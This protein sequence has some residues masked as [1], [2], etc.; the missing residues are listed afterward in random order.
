MP[1]NILQADRGLRHQRML[2]GQP[3]LAP[4]AYQYMMLEARQVRAIGNDR[5]P[6]IEP[7]LGNGRL[8]ALTT[9]IDQV[10]F[11][12]GIAALETGQQCRQE[13]TEYR[14]RRPDAHL[15]LHA[16]AEEQRFTQ[17]ILQG[18]EDMPGMLRELVPSAVN[19]TP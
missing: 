16:M 11:H 4:R 7:T 17:G 13:I 19:A 1:G 10:D 2:A 14:I 8:D 12:L 6:Q 5:Q 18:I 9:H 15:A 3:E